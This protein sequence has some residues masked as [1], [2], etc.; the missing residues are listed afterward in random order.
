MRSA[1]MR[2]WYLEELNQKAHH[3]ISGVWQTLAGGALTSFLLLMSSGLAEI[4]RVLK[5]AGNIDI[6]RDKY[7]S[8]SCGKAKPLGD[9]TVG[10]LVNTRQKTEISGTYL[11]SYDVAHG[12]SGGRFS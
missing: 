6:R 2:D 4:C 1:K 9:N 12:Q 10:W 8:R 3:C 5:P 7:I 11:R